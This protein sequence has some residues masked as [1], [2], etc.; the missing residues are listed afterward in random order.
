MGGDGRI[1]V[2]VFWLGCEDFIVFGGD[3]YYV[4]LLG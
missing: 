1:V 4:F 3:Y 2:V